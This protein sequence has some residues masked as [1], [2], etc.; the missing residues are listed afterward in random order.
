MSHSTQNEVLD[1]AIVGGGIVG[2]ALAIGL[3]ARDINVTIYERSNAFSEVGAGIGFTPNAE[4]AMKVL[5]PAI[6]A[7]F[8]KVAVQNTTDWFTWSNSGNR[9]EGDLDE[10]IYKMY[11][12]ERGFEG[13]HRAEFLNEMLN[14]IPENRVKFRKSLVAVEDRGDDKKLLMRFQDG[15]TAQADLGEL[16]YP[17]IKKAM[18]NPGIQSSVAMESTPRSA[19]SCWATTTRPRTPA[20]RTSTPSGV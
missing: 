7:A 19:A 1:V 4:S 12:G 8:K 14:L 16:F 9:E 6:H 15:T 2:A 11:V 3:L 20:T 17:F 5:D 18:A 10:P 13:C